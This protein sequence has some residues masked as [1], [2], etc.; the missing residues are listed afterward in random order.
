MKPASEDLENRRPV[1]QQLSDLFLDTELQQYHFDGMARAVADS[2]YSLSEIEEILIRELYPVCMPV[3]MSLT[4]EW[5]GFDSNWLERAIVDNPRQAEGRPLALPDDW[6]IIGDDWGKVKALVEA[7]D[8]QEA[9]TAHSLEARLAAKLAWAWNDGCPVAG[10]T[11]DRQAEIASIARRRWF[12]FERRRPK[13]MEDN[14]ANRV[15]D[16]ARG[17]CEKCER[18]GLRMAGPLISDYR[19]LAE[20]LAEVFLSE[21]Q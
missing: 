20:H 17:M 5:A 11:Q 18:G 9:M 4:G 16:L 7:I 8:R 21:R 14:R 2:P 19:W 10:A 1:W 6:H 13:S 3:L 15:E 12:S